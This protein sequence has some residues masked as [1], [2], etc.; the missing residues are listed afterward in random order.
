MELRLLRSAR[1]SPRFRRPRKRPTPMSPSPRISP[2]PRKRSPRRSRR[3]PATRRFSASGL[4]PVLHPDLSRSSVPGVPVGRRGASQGRR[5]AGFRRAGSVF[6]YA[7]GKLVLWSKV[8]D[9]TDGEAALKAGKFSKLAI[10][11]P[12][13]APYGAAAIETMKALGVYDAIQPKIVQGRASP[14]RS[15][16]STPGTRN[17]ASSRSRNSRAYGRHALGRAPETLRADPPGRGAAQEGRG[18]RGRES[19]PRVPEGPRGAG[20]HRE[21][22]VR[23]RLRHVDAFAHIW[24]RS[25]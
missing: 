2:S 25:S 12:S 15:A 9:V 19:L 7:I 22:R 5:R 21:V 1:S 17:S 3:R 11:N 20:D 4:R 13:A 6:T 10:A 16:S 24:S 18:Q 14:R 23:A 8:D